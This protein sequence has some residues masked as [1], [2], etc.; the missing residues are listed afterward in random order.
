M[1][2][3]KS[4]IPMSRL[5]TFAFICLNF[6]WIFLSIDN[7]CNA[8]I[9]FSKA[10]EGGQRIAR[11]GVKWLL[12]TNHALLA[13]SNIEKLIII[14]PHQ[15]YN[16]SPQNVIS[17]NLL[18][19]AKPGRW[20]YLAIHGTNTIGVAELKVDKQADESFKFAALYGGIADKILVA[21]QKAEQLPQVKKQ[22]Y[23]FRFL[24]V[25]SIEF[26][27]VWLHGKSDDI[28]IPLP[29][30]YDRVNAYQ[31]YSES[32]I[33]KILKPEVEKRLKAPVGTVD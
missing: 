14:D 17:N 24:N 19:A 7:N 10:P 30:T 32:Q 31:P 28:I 2:N 8:A 3:N 5:I 6:G 33:T 11:E 25:A 27:A 4:K 21:L 18:S 13:S 23:E 20:R 26:F 22:V 16:A 29:P 12:Q 9:V 15:S 1:R